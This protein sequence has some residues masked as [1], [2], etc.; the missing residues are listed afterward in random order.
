MSINFTAR[1]P[2]DTAETFVTTALSTQ[3]RKHT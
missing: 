3:R 2:E 1:I